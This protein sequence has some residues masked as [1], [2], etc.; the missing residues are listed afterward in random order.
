MAIALTLVGACV[1]ENARYYWSKQLLFEPIVGSTN[2]MRAQS[3]I[4]SEKKILLTA[5]VRTDVRITI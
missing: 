5:G 4:V 2:Y 1:H 3:Y